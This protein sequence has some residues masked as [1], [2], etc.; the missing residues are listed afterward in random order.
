MGVYTFFLIFPK[1]FLKRENIEKQLSSTSVDKNNKLISDPV[2]KIIV[3]DRTMMIIRLAM[4]EGNTLVGLAALIQSVF[5]RIIYHNSNY[6]LLTIPLF[7]LIIV[8]LTNYISKEKII[9]RIESDI[10]M[11]IQNQ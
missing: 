4:L 3:L 1:I 6:W 7:I 5:G 11:N 2:L 10:L 8:V 9:S